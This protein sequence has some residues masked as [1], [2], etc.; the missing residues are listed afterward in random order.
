MRR[1]AHLI[2]SIVLI[3]AGS[4]CGS[5]R[6]DAVSSAPASE[7]IA[8]A[9]AK[10]S[11]A[12]DPAKTTASIHVFV[13]LCDNVHQGIVPVPSRLGDGDNPRSNLYWGAG[14]GVKT[15]FS[16]SADWALVQ[17][18][19]APTPAVLE[20]CVFKH[21][22]KRVFLVAD[23]YRGSEIQQAIA[24]FLGSA[25]GLRRQALRV[26]ADSNVIE[27]GGGAGLVAYVGHNGLM[28]FS[29]S[30]YPEKQDDSPRDAMIL[31]CASK[32]YFQRPLRRAGANPLLWTPGLMAP[33][34][35]VLKAAVDAWISEQAGEVIRTKAAAAYNTYQKCGLKAARNLFATGW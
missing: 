19:Q 33:E 16:R 24:D 28:D 5:G 34:A 25:S 35:Y 22:T 15:F 1:L 3:T 12:P 18:E 26:N 30:S 23:A 6:K 27:T 11:P 10:K 31:C 4:G 13:A 7:V 8:V 20:R 17:Q 21:K 2:S 9:P 14:F 32:Q 29:L